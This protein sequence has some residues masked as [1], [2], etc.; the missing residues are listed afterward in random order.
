ML[1]KRLLALR[2]EEKEEY[3]PLCPD[4]VMELRSK[5]DRINVLQAKMHEYR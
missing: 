2:P 3:L 5:S 1:N 4:F